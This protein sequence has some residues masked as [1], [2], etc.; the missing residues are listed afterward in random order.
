MLRFI[1]L[2]I[3]ITVLARAFWRLMDSVIAEMRGEPSVGA[4]SAHGTKP[5]P[6]ASVAMERDPVCGT[7]VL[8]ERAVSHTDR[9]VTV[10]FCSTACRDAYRP[11]A[12]RRDGPA[13]F[14]DRTA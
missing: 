3:L 7:F 10:Y 4:G 2:S 8:P 11:G 12:P 1:L 5:A 6:R 14:R 9:G 13:M